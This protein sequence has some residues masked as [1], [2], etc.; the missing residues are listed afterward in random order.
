[1][2]TQIQSGSNKKIDKENSMVVPRYAKVMVLNRDP[3]NDKM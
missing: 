3:I 1:M 2:K